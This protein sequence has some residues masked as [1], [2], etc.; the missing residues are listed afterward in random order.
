MTGLRSQS[1]PVAHLGFAPGHQVPEPCS[2]LSVAPAEQG[3]P[4]RECALGQAGAERQ[5]PGTRVST[6]QGPCQAWGRIRVGAMSQLHALKQGCDSLPAWETGQVT[7]RGSPTS[8]WQ[9]Q[10]T[11]TFPCSR[12]DLE[13]SRGS[14]LSVVAPPSSGSSALPNSWWG[15]ASRP[16]TPEQLAAPRGAQA[17]TPAARGGGGRVALSFPGYS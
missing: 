12:R 14:A 15:S 4:R 11:S 8:K 1:L 16:T 9:S 3:R 7:W 13:D 5:G 10:D 17:S 2:E 6:L